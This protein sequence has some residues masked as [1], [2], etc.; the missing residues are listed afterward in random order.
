MLNKPVAWENTDMDK[1]DVIFTAVAAMD[2]AKDGRAPG[3]QSPV[4][5]IELDAVGRELGVILPPS[6]R[7]FLKRCGAGRVGTVDIFGL[8][9]NN[10]WGDIVLMNQLSR[11]H[12]SRS[13]LKFASDWTGRAYYFDTSQKSPDGEWPVVVLDA[14]DCPRLLACNFLDFMGKLVQGPITIEIAR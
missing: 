14:P 3:P 12:Y 8:P 5:D 7:K 11:E 9:R 13:Y 4:S 1:N 6:Y 2:Q 10:L